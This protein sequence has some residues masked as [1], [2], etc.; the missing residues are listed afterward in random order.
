MVP[1]LTTTWSSL[2]TFSPF[3]SLMSPYSQ[4]AVLNT[5]IRLSLFCQ[6]FNFR[7]LVPLHSTPPCQARRHSL[8]PPFS[9]NYSAHPSQRTLTISQY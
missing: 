7:T 5:N 9:P 6:T 2:S 8:L 3:L 4:F 1:I